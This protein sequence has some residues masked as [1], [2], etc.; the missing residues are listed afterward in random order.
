MIGAVI[1]LAARK[2]RALSIGA[3]VASIVILYGFSNEPAAN[4]LW[5]ALESSAPST[6]SKDVRYDAVVV[7]SGL[8]DEPDIESPS[9]N[10][11]VERLLAAFDLLRRERAQLALLSGGSNS[12]GTQ[13][14]A[15]VLAAQLVR[16]GIASERLVVEVE[17][18]NTHEN[19]MF[20]ARI[21]RERGWKKILLIT[22]AFHMPRALGCFRAEGI[23][24]DAL[25]VD[26][27][28]GHGRMSWLPRAGA[29]NTS[30]N[31]LRELAGRAVYR[32]RGYSR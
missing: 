11:N 3:G 22:S 9:Y 14:E 21:I 28:A 15:P 6:A 17:S 16:W 23:E 7:L 24:V 12:P 25:P 13:A 5:D 29:L 8:V 20:S 31:A 19:A 27:R 18:H 26:Y 2:R 10:E 1:S 4:A 30:T 32:A